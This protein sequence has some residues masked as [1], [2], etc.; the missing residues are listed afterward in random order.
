MS[1]SFLAYHGNADLRHAVINDLVRHISNG[2][3][4]NDAHSAAQKLGLISAIAGGEYDLAA[5][6]RNS[7]FPA[8]LLLVAEAIFEG[9]A[10]DDAP[11]FALAMMK[12]ATIYTELADVGWMFVEW[13]FAEAVT[14]LGP[15]RVR[16]AARN[17]GPIFR[18]L[19]ESG[20]LSAVE[21]QKAKAH[22]KRMRRR[23]QE[24][25]SEGDKL[26]ALAMG[27]VLDDGFQ[28]IVI[29]IHWTASLSKQLGKQYPLYARKLLEL[30]GNA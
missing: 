27:A 12:A 16:T 2:H 30:V 4:A 9:L 23:G 21:Q 19:A 22:A 10:P 14:E 29:A 15:S 5:A 28:H 11:H 3:L 7:G 26:V 13:M 6:H 20:S 1:I 24:A 25:P 8:P 17:A 18:K